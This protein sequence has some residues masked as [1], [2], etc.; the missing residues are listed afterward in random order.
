MEVV[1]LTL[2]QKNA[3]ANAYVTNTDDVMSFFHYNY[4]KE[5]SYAERQKELANRKFPRE[6]L[7]SILTN[8]NNQFDFSDDTQKNIDKLLNN[9]ATAIVGGQQAGL[10]SGPL[11]SI[12]KVI[13]IIQ[14]AKEQEKKLNHPVIPIF[15]IAGEDHDFQEV[16]HVFTSKNGKVNKTIIPDKQTE[17]EPVS[18]LSLNKEVTKKWMTEVVATYGD[19]E[20]TKSLLRLIEEKVSISENYTTFFAHIIAALFP[21]SGLILLDAQDEALRKMEGPFF[22]Q[23]IEK[24]AK[25]QEVIKKKEQEMKHGGYDLP[26][27]SNDYDANLFYLSEGNRVLLERTKQGYFWGKHNEVMLKQEELLTVA[28]RSPELLSNNVATRPLMQDFI[29]PTLSFIAG[30]G[31]IAYWGLLKEAFTLFQMKMP[32]VVPRQMI[33]LV[34]RHIDKR[35]KAYNLS[36]NEVLQNG[37]SEVKESW[38]KKQTPFDIEATFQS[39]E[40]KLTEIHNALQRETTLVSQSLHEYGKHNLQ[41]IKKELYNFE[42]KVKKTAEQQQATHM[43][44]L[45]DIELS[46]RPMQVP[47]ER[48]W[49]L[50]YY[51]NRYGLD[52]CERLLRVDLTWNEKHKVIKL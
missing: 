33:T 37:T 22:Q 16:N 52:F 4:K 46:L 41:Y 51:L 10:L 42:K 24:N 13:S 2:P 9:N 8:Y 28:K 7:V 25:L 12:H 14:L 31:E 39:A 5:T 45:D 21:N 19:R 49:T 44:R 6:T 15:W 50:L 47:Q 40:N 23:I 43:K 35:M 38:M 11:Y 3:F 26:F 1:E 48:M 20:Y 29:I 27:I 34:E 36:Y 32:P 30:P 17:K 18:A